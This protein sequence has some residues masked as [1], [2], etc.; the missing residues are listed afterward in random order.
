MKDG[1]NMGLIK[2]TSKLINKLKEYGKLVMFSHTIFSFSFALVSM[3][4]AQRDFRI[5]LCCFGLLF[6]LWGPAL[7]QMQSTA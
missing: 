2:M 5:F 6:A 1:T 3:A 4:L 7:V